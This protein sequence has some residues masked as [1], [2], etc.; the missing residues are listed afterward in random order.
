MFISVSTTELILALWEI[1]TVNLVK[2]ITY[3]IL[4]FSL[5]K[6]FVL[7]LVNDLAIST[8][9]PDTDLWASHSIIS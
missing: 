6:N 4:V 9:L 8:A 1:H 7:Q 3:S 2:R 5:E